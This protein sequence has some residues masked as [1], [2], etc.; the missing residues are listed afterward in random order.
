ME[1][2]TIPLPADLRWRRI[3]VVAAFLGLL[4]TFRHLAPVF[5]CFVIL[6][7]GLGWLARQIDERTPLHRKSAIASVLAILGLVAAALTFAVIRQ[8]LT[9]ITDLRANGREYLR[10]LAEHPAIDRLRGVTGLQGEELTT[11]VKDHVGTAVGYATH[12]ASLVLFLLVGFVLAIV[13]LFEQ[14][15]MDGFV[16]AI[17]PGSVTGTLIRWFGY[18]GDSI[19][20]TVKMQVVVAVVNAVVTLPVLLLLGLPHVPL[21]FLLILVSGLLPV[22]GNIFSGAVLCYVAFTAKGLWAVGVFLG[23]TFVLGKIESYYLSPRLAREHV[24]LPSIVLL[25]S[26]VLFEQ[27]FGFVGLFLSFPALFVASKIASEWRREVEELTRPG[28][29]AA[30]SVPSSG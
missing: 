30:A 12:T 5:I 18:V 15:E 6:E 7:R 9:I 1:S 29:E 28:G 17:A 13:Y 27:T 22:V 25:V 2:S 3:I 23:V 24:Q 26:L 19:A 21:L 4:Y 8:S 10:E 20:V 11:A 14:E 16:A